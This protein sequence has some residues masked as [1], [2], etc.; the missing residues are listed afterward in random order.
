ML[1]RTMEERL[2]E[3][4][5]TGESQWTYRPD[6]KT[7][8]A[9][10][11]NLRE[12]LNQ[13]NL[14]VLDGH[15][16]TDSEM[17]Q[18][19]NY[20]LDQAATTYKAACWL[21]GEN[22]IAQ[23]P[24]VRE[25]AS[26]GT[27]HLKAINNR[28]IA[29]G[30]SS[31]EVIN[32]Y[33]P[34]GG[35][36]DRRFDVTL[37]INGLPLIHIELK[38]QNYPFMDAFRQVQKY[39]NE[40]QF[41]GL[42]GLVQMFV[43]SNGAQTRYIAA[44]SSGQLNPKF[45][46]R[47]VDDE[48]KPVEDYLDFTRQV[49]NIPAAHL[50]VGNYSVIDSEKKKVLILRPYQIHAIAKVRLASCTHESGFV[51]HTTGSG[52]TLT[53]YTVTKNLLEI[54]SV[55]KT[56]FLIDRKDLDQ[57]T[58]EDFMSYAQH[59]VIDIRD[60]ESTADLERKL[61]NKDRIAIVTTIQ[62][63]QRILRRLNVKDPS[64][65]LTRLKGQIQSKR[66]VF[67]VDECHRAVAPQTKREIEKFFQSSKYSSLWYG[68][69]GT[70]IFQENQRVSLGDTPRTTKEQYGECLH[71]YTIKEALKDGSVLGFQIQTLGRSAETFQELAIKLGLYSKE[72]VESVSM[73]QLERQVIS[74]YEKKGKPFYDNDE[75]RLKVIDYI[76]NRSEGKLGLYSSRGIG[77]AYEGILTCS[78][79][80]EA[81]RYYQLFQEFIKTPGNVKESI[82]QRLPDFP[83][84]AIT[85][86][87]GENE[88]GAMV[89]QK[90]MKQ[91]LQDYNDMFGTKFGLEDLTAY[92]NDLNK[93]L[94]RKQA[95][96]ANRD[97]Q[98]DLV[99]VVDR[100]LT[101]FD[102]PCLSTIFIDRPPMKPQHL[103]QAFSRTN[104]LYDQGKRYGQI[105]TM[106]YPAN[107]AEAIDNALVLYS[108]GG[109]DEVSAPVWEEAKRQFQEAA[110][111]LTAFHVDTN[112]A[113]DLREDNRDEIIAFVKAFQS[114][115][116]TLA[117]LKVYDEYEDDPVNNTLGLNQ[118][119]L[120]RYCALYKNAIE[121]LRQNKPCGKDDNSKINL[122][123]IEYELESVRG[124]EVNY[125]YV[126]AL[127]QSHVLTEEDEGPK[128][129][130][131]AS[132]EK[133]LKFIKLYSQNNPVLGEILNNIWLE[134]N[135]NQ[136]SFRGKDILIEIQGRIRQIR[137]VK[138]KTFAQQ[139]G[140][141]AD[142][143]RAE[144]EAWNGRDVLTLVGDY[145]QYIAA[146][147][148]GSK[149][150]YRRELR[151]A[152]TKLFQEELRPLTQ[153]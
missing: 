2:I 41:R 69:T 26:L 25:D 115:D 112:E 136:E 30:T 60:T 1:E 77:Y 40:G 19:K 122:P 6:I 23:I 129:I 100:L 72:D 132:E 24:L 105:V 99:I 46:I 42:F 47:W 141:S 87:V 28:E 34:E 91:S 133:V 107:Y 80:K 20:L 145:D 134:I 125:K 65:K 61:S 151:K 51:W 103:I 119:Q 146:G 143:V 21:Y 16:I 38:S 66:V 120:D 93:R 32:Q 79:I 22:R 56:I 15:L 108:N 101:G 88:E 37:L 144:F 153:F 71:R 76:V 59:D 140:L 64:P 57:K 7:E 70:P 124:I 150:Q 11:Q 75:H 94:M 10:W 82:R 90:M 106:Q 63:L 78:S 137:N 49:L 35:E 127:I 114:V 58:T 8:A 111:G 110:K 142:Q 45:L 39:A 86:T 33:A 130:S 116:R 147:H 43:V 121:W 4:L 128:P 52:K 17:L 73:S 152:T 117:A 104:R 138:I 27:I 12:K 53:S 29:G 44:D 96:Y 18:I 126:V 31:Y 55:D 123:D 36:R 95:K 13:N 84:I 113:L 14:A 98:L 5:T 92:N 89:N 148:E 109:T 97:E 81:Q 131:K 48:N 54:P 135:L 149:L 74:V 67:V 139:W 118:D 9:L 102:A 62:K 85:Y 68:F 83:K 3:V 50:M